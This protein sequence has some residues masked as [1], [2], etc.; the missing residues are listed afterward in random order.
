MAERIDGIELN[1]LV[2]GVEHDLL[3]AKREEVRRAIRGIFNDMTNWQRE[4]QDALR[5]AANLEQKIAQ[6]GAKLE[7]L[8]AGD[9]SVLPEAKNDKSGKEVD[10]ATD[11]R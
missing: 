11:P 8:K 10:G 4:R 1:D 5:K 7:K 6:A 2:S 9:W 3:E